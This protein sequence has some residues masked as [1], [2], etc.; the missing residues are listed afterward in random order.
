MSP[1]PRLSVVV[2]LKDEAES[3]RPLHDELVHALERLGEPWEI[4]YV[5]DG[6]TDASPAV[7]AELA[8]ADDR[9]RALILDRNYGQ[10]TATIAG[11]EAARGEWL[12]TLDADGQNDPADLIDLWSTL[13]DCGADGVIGVRV[14]RHDSWVRRASS[15][16]ANAARDRLTGD[17]IADVGCSLRILRRR[18]LLEAIRFEGMHRFLPTLVR[19][20]GYSIV[21]RP[22]S[23]RP[24]RI[25]RSK[26]GVHNR[27]WRGV[28]DLLVVRRLRH[29]E[30]RYRL[31]QRDPSSPDAGGG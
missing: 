28:A 14:S 13:R 12:A 31:R 11:A 22:V 10:S 18:A 29:R 4:V 5:D 1:A 24:R 16:I 7:L 6:S 17:R 9:V 3:L 23:H 2:P 27:L 25:G 15:R 21:E 8:A 26:Y 30:I 20:A 19:M